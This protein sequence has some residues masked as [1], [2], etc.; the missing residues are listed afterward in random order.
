[1]ITLTTDAVREI[2][3]RLV[4]SG[5]DSVVR[6]A[7][8][9]GGCAGTKYVVEVGV[10]PLEGDE[11]FIQDGLTIACDR[12]SQSRVDGLELGYVDALM[13]GGWRFA[14]PNAGSTCGCGESFK[15]LLGL[16]P[17]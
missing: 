10:G 5:G 16:E 9:A 7:L 3:R 4:E 13:G 6:V 12:D 2:E 15:P 8:K 17:M 1:M 11:V 14:N